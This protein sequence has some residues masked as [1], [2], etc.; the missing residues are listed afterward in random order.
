MKTMAMACFAGLLFASLP[1][2]A[3]A[4]ITPPG[5]GTETDP[6]RISELCHLVWMGE[7]VASSA[8]KHYALLNDIDATG[9]ATWNDAGT[10]TSVSEGFKPIGTEA[11]RFTGSFDGQM[12]A[13]HGLTIRRRTMEVGLFGRIGAGATVLRLGLEGGSVRGDSAVGALVG[14]NDSG[15]V[16]QCYATGAVV[17]EGYFGIIVG[18]LVGE[19][20]GTLRQ[21]YASGSVTGQDHWVGGLVGSHDAGTIEHCYATGAVTGKRHVGGLTGASLGDVVDCYATGAVT[22][23][24]SV[25]GL[26][27]SG[28]SSAA[29]CYARGPV[30]GQTRVGGLLGMNAGAVA[31]C[32]A[33]GAVAGED[34]A[35]GLVGFN[36]GT[37]E[38]CYWDSGTSGW[39]TSAGGDGRAT[40]QMRQQSTYAWWDFV[41]QW[42]IVPDWNDGYPYLLRPGFWRVVFVAGVNGEVT[43]ATR[44]VVADG[45]D[46]TPVT[47]VPTDEFVFARW[48]DGITANPRSLT[49]VTTDMTVTAFFRPANP[50]APNGAFRAAVAAVGRGWWDLSGPYS[51]TTKGNALTLALLH[52]PTGKLSG[53]ATYAL[54]KDTPIT[55]PIKGSVKGNR[56]SVTMKGSLKGADS[57]KTLDVSLTLNL[58]VDTANRQLLGRLT[59]SIKDNGTSTPVDDPVVLGIPGNMDGT[60]SLLFQLDQTRKAVRGTAELTLSN[61]VKHTFVVRGRTAANSTAV[62]SLDGD[63]SDPA[64]SAIKIKTTITP[65]EGGWARLERLSGRGYG[66]TIGW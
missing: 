1:V 53:T 46:A 36:S 39:T 8:G 18:G 58:T 2:L 34:E 37:V 9:T 28:G 55:M 48:D 15:T 17:G 40:A 49:S 62:L 45:Q 61:Q 66:Q 63:P 5:T 16:E 14:M 31:Q 52:D 35:G 21:C 11:I 44:Q 38:Q 6:Y 3:Q 29:R 41:G 26:V 12:H 32:Y 60:W 42:G 22:G 43:G 56:G 25:G 47:A 54:A 51:T 23:E 20:T 27:G 59:G 65:L 13:I 19:N 7:T 24:R 64:S 10:D 4:A 30:T 57:T 33:T 50:R